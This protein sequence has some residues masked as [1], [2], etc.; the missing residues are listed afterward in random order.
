MLL[1]LV[2]TGTP[3]EA[4]PTAAGRDT[5]AAAAELLASWASSPGAAGP[6]PGPVALAALLGDPAAGRA[7]LRGAVGAAAGAG[8]FGGLAGVVAGLRLIPG[9]AGPADRA[10]TALV[11]AVTA[12]GW[13]TSGVGFA[14]YDL[15]SGPAGILLAHL[16]GPPPVPVA[17][18]RPIIDHLAGL[19]DAELAG[20]RI[21]AHRDHPALGWSQG[22]VVTGLAH[23]V[24]GPLVALALAGERPE[25]VAN[26]ASWLAARATTDRRGA[27]TWAARGRGAPGRPGWCYGAPGVGWALWVAGQALDDAGLREMALA[28][29]SGL[30]ATYE[31]EDSAE[32]RTLCHGAAGVLLVADAFARH[33]GSAPAADLRDR[34]AAHLRARIED[35]L[36]AGG[37][38]L[39][40][41]A[42]GVLAALLTADGGDRGW[43]PCVGLA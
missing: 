7:W 40:T 39:V 11:R 43:L 36:R 26:L 12:K 14:D 2:L 30:G 22:E 6:D 37:P 1:P 3:R 42:A 41:G 9:A 38:G 4:A 8:L 25:A 21:G 17:R 33:A 29:V 28:A 16:A 23:G 13:R 20:L 18:L 31:P 19:A 34:L 5:A 24:A 15:V 10:S 27:L 35:V 32:G